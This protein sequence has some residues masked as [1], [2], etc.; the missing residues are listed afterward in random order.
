MLRASLL[1]VLTA[2]LAAPVTAQETDEDLRRSVE[3]LLGGFEKP[4]GDA[5]WAALGEPAVPHLLAIARDE[6]Q[7][8][9]TRARAITAM[10]NFDTPDVRSYLVEILDSGDATLQ[11]KALR[12]LARTAGAEE[13]SRIAGFLDSD[14]TTLREAAAHALGLIGTDEARALL[15]ARLAVETSEAVTQAIEEELSR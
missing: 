13:M 2:L 6:A 11:R 8:R 3:T 4:A 10:G 14:N 9:S 7:P 15:T 1:L 5:D 12:P